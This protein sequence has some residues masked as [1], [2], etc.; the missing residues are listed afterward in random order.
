MYEIS[1]MICVAFYLGRRFKAAA[2][3]PL[4]GLVILVVVLGNGG[5]AHITQVFLNDLTLSYDTM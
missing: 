4:H 3:V 5:G 2:A 1:L